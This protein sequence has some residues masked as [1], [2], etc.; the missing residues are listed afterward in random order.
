MPFD[1][2]SQ[3]VNREWYITSIKTESGSKGA[4]VT[5]PKM[6]HVFPEGGQMSRTLQM[7]LDA[8]EPVA[9]LSRAGTTA[10]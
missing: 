2:R 10:S 9:Y 7:A 5:A 4:A 1:W 8:P 3:P 6:F